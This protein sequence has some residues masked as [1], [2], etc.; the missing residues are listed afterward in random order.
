M[1][2]RTE[3]EKAR[4]R[5]CG[6]VAFMAR[7]DAER[8]MRQLLGKTVEGFEMKMGWG[9][10]VAIPLHPIYIPA[11]FLKLN[12][13]P[14]QSGL[15]FNCQPTI[16]KDKAE[17]GIKAPEESNRKLQN[18]TPQP[19]RPGSA[20]G[21]NEGNPVVV[22][23]DPE[24]NPKGY[25]RFHKMLKRSVVR[26]VF[27][28]DR[29]QMCLINRMAEFVVREGPMFEA[30]IMNRE[31]N[32]RLFQFLFDNVSPEHIYYR[33]RLFSLLQG[34]SKDDW[35]TGEFRMFKGGP[36]WRPPPIIQYTKVRA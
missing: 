20:D 4:G 24:E 2:P 6:F 17:W 21:G 5:H 18:Q 1:W 12:Q 32:N 7:L 36:L 25:R 13:P 10:P 19:M 11:S 16:E 8:S 14:P 27:P 30:M 31:L 9:K 23:P 26:V 15:P 35:R 22:R 33:W 34:D 29:N 3:E 28:S